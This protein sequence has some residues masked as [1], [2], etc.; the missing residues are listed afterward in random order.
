MDQLQN[1]GK[2]KRLLNQYMKYQQANYIISSATSLNQT[3][4]QSPE[5][6][7]HE[8]AND[9]A[10][11]LYMT[12]P[13]IALFPSSFTANDVNYD[14]RAFIPFKEERDHLGR[15]INSVSACNPL[16][17]LVTLELHAN[18]A[19]KVVHQEAPDLASEE[20]R[21]RKDGGRR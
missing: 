6:I 16:I 15:L 12:E 21:H 2:V 18:P 3:R 11:K 1:K 5:G 10:S 14:K 8:E 13:Q 9:I 19:A 4:Q 17:S 20:G 7:D